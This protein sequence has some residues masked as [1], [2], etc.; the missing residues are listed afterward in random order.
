MS[1]II[2]PDL[3]RDLSTEIIPMLNH[4]RAHIRKRAILLLYKVLLKY[5]GAFSSG[6][7]RLRDKLE[8]PDPGKYGPFNCMVYRILKRTPGVVAA[9][10]NV[11]CELARRNPEDYLTLAPSLF[12]LMTTSSN[13][14]MLI[15]I[16]KLVTIAIIFASCLPFS[17][18]F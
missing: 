5:P 3:A 2:T 4:S 11:L 7:I 12:H 8:D 17:N 6:I 9:A 18:R 16:I 10:I 14:W 1:H 15:K 13:N